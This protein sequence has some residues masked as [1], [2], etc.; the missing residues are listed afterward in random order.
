[1]AVETKNRNQNDITNHRDLWKVVGRIRE[2]VAGLKREN[3]ISLALLAAIILKL[4][5]A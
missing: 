4:L 1:M 5:F 3:R 2:D